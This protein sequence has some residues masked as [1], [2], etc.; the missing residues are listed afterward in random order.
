[1]E[2]Y[3]LYGKSG[4]GKSH[5]AFKVLY[6]LKINTVIDDGLLIINKR[7]VAGKTAKNENSLI[8]ATKRATF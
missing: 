2:I 6:D 4:T 5:K 1:M 8:A 3:G 7:K